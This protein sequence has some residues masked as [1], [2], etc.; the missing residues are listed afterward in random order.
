[1][2]QSDL[3]HCVVNLVTIDGTSPVFIAAKNGYTVVVEMLVAGGCDVSQA[4][5]NSATPLM[6]AVYSDHHD[7][8]VALLKHGADAALATTTTYGP[9][10]AGS[11]AL[12]VARQFGRNAMVELLTKRRRRRRGGKS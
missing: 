5:N 7:I 3:R 6:A 11:T 8:A 2:T 10:A 9:V 1:M 4:N 12:S